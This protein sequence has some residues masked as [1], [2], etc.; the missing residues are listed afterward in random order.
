MI[1]QPRVVIRRLEKSRELLGLGRHILVVVLDTLVSF[2]VEFAGV[3][4]G[5][6]FELLLGRDHNRRLQVLLGVFDDA[7]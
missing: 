6:Q 5:S 3:D 4:A 2:S 7:S 1:G